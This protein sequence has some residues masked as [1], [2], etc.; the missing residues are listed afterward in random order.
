M[1]MLKGGKYDGRDES[2][3]PAEY[4][5]SEQGQAALKAGQPKEPVKQGEPE[6]PEEVAAVTDLD[7]T[8]E[9][10]ADDT[11]EAA[12]VEAAVEEAEAKE[13]AAEEAAEDRAEDREEA[14]IAKPA[15]PPKRHR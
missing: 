3:V 1:T 7:A 9:D 12:A 2:W 4:L 10:E 14:R 13:D 6:E 11:H 5:N 15:K 8:R